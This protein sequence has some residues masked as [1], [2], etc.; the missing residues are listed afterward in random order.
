MYQKKISIFDIVGCLSTAM[1]LISPVMVN[2]QR[3]V[4]YIAQR[5]AGEAGLSKDQKNNVLVAGFL[6]DC[7]AL[8]LEERFMTL[9]FEG[10][11][12]TSALLLHAEAGY[13]LLKKFRPFAEVAEYIRFHHIP[14]AGGAGQ[15]FDKEPVPIG[16]HILHLADRVE[17]LIDQQGHIL[18]QAKSIVERIE[19]SSG[20]LFAPHLIEA[21]KSLA[22]KES[23]WLD[24]KSLNCESAWTGHLGLFGPIRIDHETLRELTAI[25]S[26]II[27][28]RSRF[29]A[30]HSSGVA[31]C[32]VH[33]AGLLG[34]P[35]N[36]RVMMHIAGSFHDLGKLAVPKEILEKPDRLTD[37]EFC[38]I[39]A[40]PYYTQ[41]I[42]NRF[43]DLSTISAWASEHHERIDGKGYPHHLQSDKITLGSRIMAVADVFTAITEDRPYRKGMENRQVIK[44]LNNL[45]SDHALDG[46]I[47]NTLL[48]NFME[49]NIVRLEAQTN[50]LK[51]YREFNQPF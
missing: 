22:D 4:G 47:V 12:N 34:M 45:A 49:I 40:H 11:L 24:I 3:R 9:R 1:D 44:V 43:K 48:A 14:W 21:F 39:K 38:I 26:R 6:H 19:K 2:H 27:D 15:E 42:L 8:S 37:Q 16:S 35:D 18:Q 50:T 28:F 30:T 51:E 32:A 31:A 33:L 46:D 17:I 10:S 25:F 13:R 41:N 20:P 36:E 5:I 23:F 29:T 7:G